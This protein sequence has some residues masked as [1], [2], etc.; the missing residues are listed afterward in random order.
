MVIGI[1]LIPLSKEHGTGAF[2]YIQLML[3]QMGNYQLHN[4]KF[5]VYKQKNISERYLSIPKNLNVEYVN[6]PNVGTGMKRFLFEQTLFYFY[7]KSCDVFYSYCTSMPFFI[8]AKKIFTLHDV[9]FLT[10]KERYGYI[11][12]NYLKVITKICIRICDKIFTVS[13]YSK[14][15][16]IKYYKVNP[17][18][19]LITYNFIIKNNY[20]INEVAEICDSEGNKMDLNKPFFL[21][22]GNIHPG[23]NIRRMA[24]GFK[25]FNEKD[26]IYNLL[27]C[28]KPANGGL[29][30]LQELS[31]IPNVYYLGF[32]S[33]SNVEWLF[34]NCKAVVL[35]SLCE[36]FGIPPLEG[37]SYNKPALVSNTTSLPEVVGNAGVCV[38]PLNID[39]IAAGFHKV[40]NNA[41]QLSSFCNVQIDKFSPN[42]SVE[43]FMRSL[44]LD[45]VR[46]N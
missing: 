26:N 22:V 15:E 18:K 34:R 1:N 37:F 19:L 35:V 25:K 46:I 10:E 36:G 42:E 39:E 6:I 7:L 23:K 9:Y 40:E 28:G 27:V 11:Q 38:N 14:S 24:Y 2:R 32:Q 16:I 12:R 21:F 44:G 8:K 4:C 3:Q 20:S 13:N 33:R 30:I 43:I 5:I 17:S 41:K 29:S 45:F 31:M